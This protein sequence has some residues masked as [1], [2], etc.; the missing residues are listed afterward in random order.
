[1]ANQKT[2]T[3][4][5][6]VKKLVVDA[7]FI[8]RN[9]EQKDDNGNKTTRDYLSFELIEPFGAEELLK[10]VALKAKWDKY[11]DK[12][13]L[14]RPDRVFSNMSYYARKALRTAPEIPVKVTIEPVT[15]KS[16]K[17]NE[18]VTYAAIFAEPTFKELEDEKPVEMVVKG[19]QAAMD[20]ALLAGKALCIKVKPKDDD[21]DIGLMDNN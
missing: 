21:D 7:R 14:V 15:Y 4:E 1:M 20:F 2:S 12:N 9:F 11:D 17:S 3:T 16:K 10:D 8:M 6:T 5:A 13:R 18:M 19:A